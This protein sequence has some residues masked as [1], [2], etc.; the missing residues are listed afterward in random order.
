MS[1]FKLS[2]IQAKAILDV[3]LQK[4]TGLER[5]KI[6]AE[7]EE[8][9]KTIDYLKSILSDKTLRMQ[10]IKDEL[11]EVKEKYGDE[12]RTDI[13]Y[14]GGD[15]SDEDMIPDT[16]VVVTISHAGYIKRT[17]LSE[18]RKQNRGEVGSKAASTRD[19]D[20]IENVFVATN[21][22]YMLFFTSGKMLLDA[23]IP[24]CERAQDKA[25]VGL[26]KT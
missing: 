21:H 24:K 8:L 10:I 16:E 3:R 23:R 1:E 13:E 7:Y 4:L 5:D 22:Q 25:R 18:Y 6:K 9:M 2:E 19:K 15:V 11:L 20:F 17:A 12:R 14:A 26:F